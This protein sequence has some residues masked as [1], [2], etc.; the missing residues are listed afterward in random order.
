MMSVLARWTP[1]DA[2]TLP[3]R[4]I[5]RIRRMKSFLTI[6]AQL[7]ALVAAFALPMIAIFAYTVFD[8]AR[9]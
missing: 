9:H 1:K 7:L 8:D 2:N 5:N 3:D 4:T 6:R